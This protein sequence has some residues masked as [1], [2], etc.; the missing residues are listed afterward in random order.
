MRVWFANG[1]V[2]GIYLV[3]DYIIREMLFFH[4]CYIA[5]LKDI[6]IISNLITILIYLVC[7]KFLMFTFPLI[8]N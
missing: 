8:Y 5:S 6:Q 2:T 7:V 3:F 4:L 1:M